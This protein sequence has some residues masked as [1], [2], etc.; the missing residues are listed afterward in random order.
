MENIEK[1]KKRSYIYK[2]SSIE[3][4]IMV[5]DTVGR[6]RQNLRFWVSMSLTS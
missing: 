3:K 5:R 2:K 6:K 1:G 4:Y